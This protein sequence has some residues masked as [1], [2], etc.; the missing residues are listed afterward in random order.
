MT[1]EIRFRV[2]DTVTEQMFYPED[3]KYCI[4][5]IGKVCD[6]ETDDGGILEN[7]DYRSKSMFWTG[8]KD[9]NDKKIYAGDI[10]RHEL[11]PVNGLVSYFEGAFIWGVALANNA[12]INYNCPKFM[13]VIG[14]IHENPELLD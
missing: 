7:R 8:M 14:N 3:A 2:W 10:I 9:K 6:D 13:E 4:T 11:H 5:M 12:L 1:T